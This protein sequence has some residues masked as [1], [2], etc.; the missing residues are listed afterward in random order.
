MHPWRTVR[1]ALTGAEPD[2]V[3][4]DRIELAPGVYD[5]THGETFPLD[6]SRGISLSGSASGDTILLAPDSMQPVLRIDGAPTEVLLSRLTVLRTG[7]RTSPGVLVRR[8]EA[9]SIA[10]CAVEG[11]RPGVDADTTPVVCRGSVFADNVGTEHGGAV[12]TNGSLSMVD[13]TVRGNQAAGDGGG[14]WC[15]A[16]SVFYDCMFEANTAFGQAGG[17]LALVGGGLVERCRFVSNSVRVSRILTS[18]PVVRAGGGGLVCSGDTLVRN[19]EIADNTYTGLFTA[20][21]E[22]PF[23]TCGGGGLAIEAPE[24]GATVDNCTISR[25]RVHVGRTVRTGTTVTKVYG[26]GVLVGNAAGGA[27]IR[28]CTVEQNRVSTDPVAAG[29]IIYGWG[30]GIGTDNVRAALLG[31]VVRGNQAV[32]GGG[33]Y[34][35]EGEIT[36]CTIE[37]NLA[38]T[39]SGRGGGVRANE[40]AVQLR[41]CRIA[42]NQAAAGG[43]L[44]GAARAEGCWI[45]SNRATSV[46]GG[47]YGAAAQLN[48]IVTRNSAPNGSAAFVGE[49][50]GVVL[51]NNTY[52]D[53]PANAGQSMIA[54]RV[55]GATLVNN[56]LAGSGPAAAVAVLFS[57]TPSLWFNHF[58]DTP[59]GL[60]APFGGP[61]LTSASAL[62]AVVPSATRNQ[63]GP[64]Q[65]A[66]PIELDF[67]PLTSSPLIDA[68]TS[69]VIVPTT[70]ALGARRPVG[71]GI[72]MGAIEAGGIPPTPSPNPTPIALP[73]RAYKGLLWLK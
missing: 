2:L 47:I 43:G 53:N 4:G 24:D 19:C 22:V 3:A 42:E 60:Y 71:D 64:A 29:N 65:F 32:D 25:N 66:N 7:G 58:D 37:G 52:Y 10:W 57:T 68:G 55:L 5:A 39:I 51:V 11:H 45:V 28:R 31:C 46:G 9:L 49:R 16:P 1:H 30:G 12:R 56:V 23:L 35:L 69:G 34:A 26:G 50:T 73:T 62:N 48:N 6:L 14:V 61:V 54:I 13:C 41:S 8:S 67:A 38:S 72:D 21:P 63:E 17:G 40:A 33:V 59:G 44:S 36:D 20:L 27:T 70:D 15:G 18:E